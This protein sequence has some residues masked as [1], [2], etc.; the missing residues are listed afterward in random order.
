MLFFLLGLKSEGDGPCRLW[1]GRA[2]STEVRSFAS[3]SGN[4]R[5]RGEST[6]ISDRALEVTV[7]LTQNLSTIPSYALFH[8]NCFSSVI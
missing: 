7:E 6:I 4:Y 2:G 5:L 3:C 1:S 8:L